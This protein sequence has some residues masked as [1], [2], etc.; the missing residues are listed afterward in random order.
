VTG[1]EIENST[2][3]FGARVGVVGLVA[4]MVVVIFVDSPVRD[5]FFPFLFFFPVVCGF[6]VLF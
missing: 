6:F 5:F 2:T 3:C 4:G 1:L